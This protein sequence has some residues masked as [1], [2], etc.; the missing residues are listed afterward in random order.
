MIAGIVNFNKDNAI[1]I[2]LVTKLANMGCAVYMIHYYDD[3]INIIEKMKSHIGF[4][5]DLITCQT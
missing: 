4:F 2:K 1:P 5:L 3:Y